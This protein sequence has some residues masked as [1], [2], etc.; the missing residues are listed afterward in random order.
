MAHILKRSVVQQISY[1]AEVS[2]FLAKGGWAF[3]EDAHIRPITDPQC[4]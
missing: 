1:M 2:I 4:G 3:I